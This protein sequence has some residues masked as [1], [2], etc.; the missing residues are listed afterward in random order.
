M[1]SR[2]QPI[3]VVAGSGKNEKGLIGVVSQEVS[4]PGVGHLTNSEAPSMGKPRCGQG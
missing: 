2:G 4:L 1:I 3:Q